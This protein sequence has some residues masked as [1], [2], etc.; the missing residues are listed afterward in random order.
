VGRTRYPSRPE[1]VAALGHLRLLLFIGALIVALRVF[2]DRL[3]RWAV[4][5][6]SAD[7]VSRVIDTTFAVLGALALVQLVTGIYRGFRWARARHYERM[8]QDP[9][10]S[11]EVPPLEG[12]VKVLE[13]QFLDGRPL[14]QG[15][16]LV[17]GI[18]VLVVGRNM[19]PDK[20][21]PGE[22]W[23]VTDWRVIG[24]GML[25]GCLFLVIAFMFVRRWLRARRVE[26]LS[27]DDDL[28]GD[29]TD[30]PTAARTFVAEVPDLTISFGSSAGMRYP[31]ATQVTREQNVF[32]RPPWSILYL[33]LFDNEARL[34]AFLEGPWRA[35]GYVHF[36]RAA[37]SV[38][39]DVIRAARDGAAVFINSHEWLERELE[40]QPT[41]PL[42]IGRH[43]LHDVGE[44][45]IRVTDPAGSYPVRALLVH[46]SF[47]QATL[48]V[49]LDRVN[50][51]VLDLSGYQR[52]NVGTGFELQRIVDR[53][54]FERT[55]VIADEQS[56]EVFLEA[57]VRE[58]WNHMASGSPNAEHVGRVV[59]CRSSGDT[60]L[61]SA[62]Q[63]RLDTAAEQGSSRL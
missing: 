1:R 2:R 32:G 41:E 38:G 33:R 22:N 53:F 55:A 14:L 24:T 5:Y 18:L 54:P 34:R 23:R 58:A 35:C 17:T 60:A 59:V 40:Q 10:R 20:D 47:W 57:Q 43:D 6:L 9:A 31:A 51:V 52:E 62:L 19:I 63:Q 27:S 25:V 48:D 15:A 11:A 39:V 36:M 4:Q 61:A 49:L 21:K 12:Q 50:V 56:D 44:G 26:H 8:L 13:W 29:P 30:A 42:P 28:A 37:T 7:V 3:E 45:D 46:G 16:L